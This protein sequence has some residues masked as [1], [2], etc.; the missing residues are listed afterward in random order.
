MLHRSCVYLQEHD[1]W[2]WRCLFSPWIAVRAAA[3]KIIVAVAAQ[4][5]RL[6]LRRQ[7]NTATERAHVAIKAEYVSR[8]RGTLEL[9]FL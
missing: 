8:F 2:M 1:A 4:P 6:L 9:L 7:A 5:V 3:A